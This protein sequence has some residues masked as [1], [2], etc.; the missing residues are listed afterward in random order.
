MGRCGGFFGGCGPFGGAGYFNDA[1]GGNNWNNGCINNNCGSAFGNQASNV[2]GGNRTVYYENENV[3]NACDSALFGGVAQNN[4]GSWDGGC[5]SY[6]CNSGGNYGGWGGP[7][8]YPVLPYGGWGAGPV[9]NNI[10]YGGYKPKR[11]GRKGLR[12]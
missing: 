9:Y 12:Y 4:L 6:G 8:G 11:Y 1:Y 2:T 3:I 7:V 5:G 10:G